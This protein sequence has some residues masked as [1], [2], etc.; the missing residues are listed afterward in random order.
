MYYGLYAFSELVANYS[1]WLPL[2]VTPVRPG[3]FNHVNNTGQAALRKQLHRGKSP[4]LNFVAHAT[5]DRHGA[6]RVLLLLKDLNDTAGVNAT[7]SISVAAS[8]SLLQRKQTPHQDIGGMPTPLRCVGT[9]TRLTEPTGEPASKRRYSFLLSETPGL[10]L[11]DLNIC[12]QAIMAFQN[13][14]SPMRD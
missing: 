12:M 8:S 1:R 9:I 7:V 4:A 6:V 3:S 10:T 11:H 2:S 13:E 5:C 14:V